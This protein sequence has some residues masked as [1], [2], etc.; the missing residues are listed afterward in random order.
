MSGRAVVAFEPHNL[1][2]GKIVLEAQDV[3]DLGPAPAID[4]LV[5]IADTGEVAATLR[6]Q[7]QPQILRHVGV[8]ILVHQHV[9]EALLILGQHIGMAAPERQAMHQQIA[10]IAGIQRLEALLIGPVELAALAVAEHAGLARRNGFGAKAAVLPAVDEAGQHAARPALL[11]EIGRLDD[12]LQQPDLV[13]HV[14]NGEVALQ[15]DQFG[16]AAQDPGR[17]RVERAEPGHALGHIPDQPGDALLHLARRL[18][19]EGDGEDLRGVGL[20][21]GDQMGNAGREHA[22]L[23]SAGTGQYQDRPFGGFH[24]LALF[25]VEAV[26]IGRGLRHEAGTRTRRQSARLGPVGQVWRRLW[27]VGG[28]PAC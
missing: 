24:R 26:E 22:G 28:W 2:A 12:L 4:R 25:G 20:A 7:A 21:R 23:A 27:P 16:V 19:G 11:I 6:E 9:A 15:A 13:I 5:V 14:E 3:V 10:E 17:D 18:V 1:R 8:L